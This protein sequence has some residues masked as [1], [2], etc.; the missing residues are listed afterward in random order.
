MIW[1]WTK[2]G[3]EGRRGGRGANDGLIPSDTK[4]SSFFLTY[5]LV[6]L[7]FCFKSGVPRLALDVNA[8]FSR[9]HLCTKGSV[10]GGGFYP[11]ETMQVRV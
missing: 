4:K 11:L 5:F 10:G 2:T 8:A 9:G 6:T 1:S 3:D 7:V